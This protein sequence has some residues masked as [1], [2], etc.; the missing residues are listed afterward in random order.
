MTTVVAKR[1]LIVHFRLRLVARRPGEWSAVAGVFHYW[2][3]DEYARINRT[4]CDQS[5]LRPGHYSEEC[6]LH[7]G[8][9]GGGYDIYYCS[10]VKAAD[11]QE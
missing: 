1:F 8:D 4:D 9:H 2:R 5:W 3:D 7:A 10:I 11:S 6:V